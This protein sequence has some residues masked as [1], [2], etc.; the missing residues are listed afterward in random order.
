MTQFT[1]R[2]AGTLDGKAEDF[3]FTR[4]LRDRGDFSLAE[5]EA[6][7]VDMLKMHGWE[8]EF[9]VCEISRR[10]IPDMSFTKC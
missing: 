2:G 4:V 7:I 8:R 6:W 9:T 1:V 5:L 3:R 10:W